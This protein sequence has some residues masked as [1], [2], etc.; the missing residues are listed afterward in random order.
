MGNVLFYILLAVVALLAIVAAVL[1]VRLLKVYYRSRRLEIMRSYET[2]LYAAL[3]K[4]GPERTLETLFPNPDRKALEEVLLRMGDEG[5]EGWKEN[6]VTLY[7]LCG[8]TDKRLRQLRSPLKSRRSDAAR[9][10]GRIC[11][12]KAVPQLKELLWDSKEEVKEAALY[13]LGRIG[14]RESLEAMLE[15]LERGDRWTQEKVSEAVEEAGDDSRQLLMELLKDE[16]PVRRTFAAEVMGRVGGAEEAIYLEMTMADE[17]VD[18]RARAADSLGKLRQHSSR[19]ALLGALDDPAWEVRSQ[20]AKAL[21]SIGEVQ[22]AIRL[23]EALQ[24]REWWVRNNA[25]AALREMGEA[26][27]GPLVDAL[28]DED[29]FAR[30]TAAQALEESSIVERIIKEIREGRGVEEDERILHRLAE[31]GCV[32]T[33]SQ[34]LSD[35]PD[36]EVKAGLIALFADIQEPA[37]REIIAGA[38]GK[39]KTTDRRED[40]E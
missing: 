3:Y 6:V 33:I 11:D 10:L 38:A 9:R 37:L 34:V 39:E 18:V 29:R 2:M 1:M 20:A 27:E 40:E 30:E 4:I 36:D 16:N 17:E 25:A 23:R 35:L 15:A 7:E 14:T 13:A 12:P 24:D 5:A 32:G 21:G 26:G 19:P 8:F 22:D 28:W 31:I